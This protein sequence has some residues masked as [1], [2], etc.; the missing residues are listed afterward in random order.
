MS[1][2]MFFFL[3]LIAVALFAALTYAVSH[4]GRN[5]NPMNRES[6][7]LQATQIMTF[8]NRVKTAIDRLRISG[9]AENQLDFGNTI[10][11]TC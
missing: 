10:W 2:E 8:G 7:K 4:N 5:Q 11:D 6:T 9:C 3:I 1:A